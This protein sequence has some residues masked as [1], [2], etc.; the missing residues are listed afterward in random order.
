MGQRQ[1][2]HNA[3]LVSKLLSIR[4]AERRRSEARGKTYRLWNPAHSRPAAPRPEA[5]LPQADRVFFWLDTVPYV[6]V[7]RFSALEEEEPRGA[8]PFAPQMLVC[9]VL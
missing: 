6:D 1:G 8:P 7:S 2:D 9:L 5:K 4:H 3:S